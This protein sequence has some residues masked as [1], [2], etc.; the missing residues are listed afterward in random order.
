M[1]TEDEKITKLLKEINRAYNKIDRLT[2]EN[3]KLKN[4]VKKLTKK[5]AE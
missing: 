1:K 2:A 3:K 4:E 5:K